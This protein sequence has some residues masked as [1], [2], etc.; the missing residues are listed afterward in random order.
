MTAGRRRE[1]FRPST[2]GTASQASDPIW[3]YTHLRPV[4]YA[5]WG[6]LKNTDETMTGH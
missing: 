4:L 3:K 5:E 6:C 1:K 2:D